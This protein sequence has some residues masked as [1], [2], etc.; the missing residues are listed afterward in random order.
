MLVIILSQKAEILQNPQID[1]QMEVA[2][3]R[4]DHWPFTDGSSRAIQK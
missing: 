4:G 3:L 1:L 2:S